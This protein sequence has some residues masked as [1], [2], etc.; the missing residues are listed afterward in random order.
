MYNSIQHFIEKNIPEIENIIQAVLQGEK[1]SGDL[2][3]CVKEKI[4]SLGREMM[5]EIYEAI[6]GEIRIS[7]E[8]KKN[9]DIEHR[10]RQKTIV[11]VMGNITYKRTGYRKKGTNEYMYLLDRV[12][13]F[14]KGQK[15]TMG[16]AAQALEETIES[17]YEKGGRS[18]DEQAKISK[19][20]IKEKVHGLDADMRM[21]EPKRKEKKKHKE[22]HIVA[23]E[24]HVAAQFVKKKGD[25]KRGSDGR[26][27][28]TLMPKLVCVYEGSI[29]ESG[30]K[31]KAPRYKLIGK[32]YFC[33]IYTGSRNNEKLWKEVADYIEA[34]YDTDHLENVYIAGDGA[35]WIRSGCEYVIKGRF[36]LDKYHMKYYI[37]QS[38]SHLYDSAGDVKD[39][40]WDAL[41]ATDECALK[42][43]Y[44]RIIRVT[45]S[46]SKKI[47][48]EK[49]LQYLRNNW[50][51][52]K[53]RKVLGGRKYGAEG[54]VS[55]VLSS[56]LSSRPMGW[57]VLGCDRMA[58]LRAF[59][60]NGG[61]VIDLL[62]YQKES[63]KKTA[64]HEQEDVLIK[65]MQKK[66]S[67]FTYAHETKCMIPGLEQKKMKWLRDC[68]DNAGKVC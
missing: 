21:P 9:W 33:G 62:K 22:L 10:G 3:A 32:R 52:I 48:V 2:S 19:Q 57:S 5:S 59:K 41:N 46:D 45:E 39:K 27:I 12:L 23:D 50:D 68:I 54:Q 1:E 26:K 35:P 38:V 66:M 25:L 58:R 18:I 43:I 61:K 7:V 29:N 60:R 67:R 55:H 4:L 6:D 16:A 17:S 8:R 65:K 15:V 53:I 31:S 49:A 44:E 42:S 47:E 36:V 24:D 40:I 30:D 14:E 13:G 37:N 51:G 64:K 56:R 28:N 34:N 20:A 63:R 11:D